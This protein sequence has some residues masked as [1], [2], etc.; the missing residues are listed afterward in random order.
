MPGYRAASYLA[1]TLLGLSLGV[2][3]TGSSGG[4]GLGS[5]GSSGAPSSGGSAQSTGGAVNGS[6]GSM[7]GGGGS[8]GGSSNAMCPAGAR[9]LD[10]LERQDYWGY[11]F[12]FNDATAGGSQTPSGTFAPEMADGSG[13]AV[14]TSGTGFTNWGA[15]VGFNLTGVRG[16]YDLGQSGGIRFRAKGPA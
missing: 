16:C 4:D 2:A 12:A 1:L 6:G 3:C 9:V 5:G 8:S 7:T 11:W 15:G 10:D 14:H 13:Y